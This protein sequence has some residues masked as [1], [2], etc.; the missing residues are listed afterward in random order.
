M[1]SNCLVVRVSFSDHS[2]ILLYDTVGGNRC[3]LSGG[4]ASK[5][6]ICKVIDRRQ[7][8]AV[9]RE[10]NWMIVAEPDCINAA[11]D[12]FI[13]ALDKAL[14]SSTTCVAVDRKSRKRTPWASVELVKLAKEKSDTYNLLKKYPESEILKKQFK[15]ISRQ[16]TTQVRIDK[17][18]FYDRYFADCG[19]N[20]RKYW[21]AVNAALGKQNK[22]I[23]SLKVNEIKYK[24][25][26]NEQFLA[27]EMNKYLVNVAAKLSQKIDPNLKPLS[28]DTDRKI[29]NSFGFIEL[30]ESEVRGAIKKLPNKNST[31]Q[32]G[33]A[34]WVLKENDILVKPMTY[35]FNTSIH[36]GIFPNV[37]KTSVVVPVY[38]S[39][40]KNDITNYRPIAL[41][42]V[43][44]KV[45]ES[46]IKERML[47][48]LLK[49]NY[50][51][52]QQYGF[53]PNKSTDD[54]LVDQVTEIT[55][56]LEEGKSVV[57]VYL[58]ITRAFDTVTH[59]ILLTKLEN[60]GFRGRMLDWFE[61][62]LVNRYQRV[63]LNN[64][65]GKRLTVECGV[66]QG[67]IMGPLMFL[68]YIN[69][70]LLMNLRGSV[71]CFADDTALIYNGTDR[72]NILCAIKQD[73]RILAQWFITHR[74]FPNAAKSKIISFG[75]KNLLN[76]NGE[77][78]MH[79]SENCPG[80]CQCE[81]IA[82]VN[83]IKY[84]GIILDSK[85][86]W[87]AQTL[88]LQN[89]LRQLNYTLYHARNL[90][91]NSHL[92]R[93][94]MA[95][96]ESKLR[97]GIKSWGNA[98]EYH[99]ETIRVLQRAAI[100]TIVGIRAGEG[101]AAWFKKLGILNLTNLYRYATICYVHKNKNKFRGHSLSRATVNTRKGSTALPIP[102]WNKFHSR[103]QVAYT[104]P[105]LYNDLPELLREVPG[106]YARFRH[107][108]KEHL[109]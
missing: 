60:A 11:F 57:A 22:P 89:N 58:D 16:V 55:K 7:V 56:N 86:T 84:L 103:L 61:S 24:V 62:H 3:T 105:M 45:F 72:G 91:S 19:Y 2:A 79:S 33:L 4:T 88:Y 97:Y 52:P 82:R 90:F 35:L 42:S 53:L 32:D 102:K 80:N 54:A 66:P 23:D 98:S 12:S 70:L 69:D 95:L 8:T 106:S 18:A 71:Y 68:I 94:Y 14:T 74:L 93:L 26:N 101:T 20:T 44:S 21:S 47:K 41:L 40:D 46:L 15:F 63:K 37:L 78:R 39:G 51:S 48:F 10:Y 77:I 29:V 65:L 5:G 49:N 104:A 43:I 31:G 108:L 87:S 28:N 76:I 6:K 67:S 25:E 109:L 75:Y 96:Y 107:R 99:L 9:L 1:E 92:V 27:N 83:E 17:K 36:K 73:M 34:S 13:G 64:V 81:P 30:T 50:F 100:R 38:K 85:M 59:Q